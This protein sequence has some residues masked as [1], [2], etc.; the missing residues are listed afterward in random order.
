DAIH[1]RDQGD[2]PYPADGLGRS[3]EKVALDQPSHDPA[4]WIH[5]GVRDDENFLRV[6]AVGPI[7]P[8]L[9]Q[10]LILGIAGPGEVIIDDI[11]LERIDEPGVNLVVNGDF[12]SEGMEPWEPRGIASSSVVEDGIGVDE[13]RA[14]RVISS[15]S[16][17]DDCAS[18]DSVSQTFARGALDSS[19]M[20]R[21]S[22][23]FRHVRGSSEIYARLLRGV[24]VRVDVN[25]L[26]PGAPNS[27]E[28]ET[29]PPLVHWHGRYPEMPESTDPVWLSVR[30]RAEGSPVSSVRLAWRRDAQGATETVVEMADDGQGR[31]SFAGDGV[32]G[33]EL[34]PQPHGTPILY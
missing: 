25:Q 32:Y 10:R 27:R 11:S 22:L 19:V 23:S 21:L 29:M 17:E 30:V 24:S 31:D 14:L 2:W 13:S 34:P 18:I 9:I 16:C 5:S 12:E 4:N 20:Y 3:L 1:Y 28:Q 8:L 26:S 33:V 7:D 6:E 15:G